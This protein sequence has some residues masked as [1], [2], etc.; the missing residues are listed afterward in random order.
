MQGVLSQLRH[1]VMQMHS[2]Q[3]RQLDVFCLKKARNERHT[4]YVK[5]NNMQ[6]MIVPN[7][8]ICNIRFGYLD[9]QSGTLT[10]SSGHKPMSAMNSA[11]ADAARKR[12]V[13]YLAAVSAPA[14]S[15]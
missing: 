3:K 11:D 13:W 6:D 2:S 10:A 5:A 1:P 7:A 8:I 9:P 4:Q 14:R 12:G 15:A